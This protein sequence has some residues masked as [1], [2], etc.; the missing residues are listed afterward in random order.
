MSVEVSE[1]SAQ[2]SAVAL[3]SFGGDLRRFTFALDEA[4]ELFQIFLPLSPIYK[5]SLFMMERYLKFAVVAE[6]ALDQSDYLVYGR[7]LRFLLALGDALCTENPAE[8]ATTFNKPVMLLPKH[9]IPT[10]VENQGVFQ[11]I[12][13]SVLEQLLCHATQ[14]VQSQEEQNGE[15]LKELNVQ[16]PACL[17]FWK[18]LRNQLACVI[19]LCDATLEG[20]FERS[21]SAP[22]SASIYQ[23]SMCS[24]WTLPADNDWVSWRREVPSSVLSG[25][26]AGLDPSLTVGRQLG[27]DS[28]QLTA[29]AEK[30][31]LTSSG[32][33]G[34][35][36]TPSDLDSQEKTEKLY[37][38]SP[39]KSF[40]SIDELAG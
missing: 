37:I 17:K 1:T 25:L 35:R 40:M 21:N 11:Q 8:Q 31:T 30:T 34:S 39:L 5:D 4:H 36:G 19:A 18:A 28:Q 10:R 24:T 7:Q 9:P 22:D 32:S 29:T 26:R 16:V 27:S 23:R 2:S 3:E 20:T 33:S 6:R 13:D 14:S 38:S 12:G 15:D